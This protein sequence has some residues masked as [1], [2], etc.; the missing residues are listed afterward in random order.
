LLLLTRASIAVNLLNFRRS[1]ESSGT[2]DLAS[3]R[4]TGTVQ[5]PLE[6]IGLVT[7]TSTAWCF[8]QA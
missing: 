6:P 8:V 5:E 2:A 4:S 7:E 3:L 1:I